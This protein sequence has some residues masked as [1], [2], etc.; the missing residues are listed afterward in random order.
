MYLTVKYSVLYN[1]SRE[2]VCLPS[3]KP[4]GACTAKDNSSSAH[5]QGYRAKDPKILK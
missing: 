3:Q 4:F 5:L 2:T 1:N